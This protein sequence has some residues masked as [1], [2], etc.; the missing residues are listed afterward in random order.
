M[1]IVT[2]GTITMIHSPDG[3]ISAKGLKDRLKMINNFHDPALAAELNLGPDW[4]ITGETPFEKR[5]AY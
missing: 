1:V 2:G 3:Y 4:L 5:V